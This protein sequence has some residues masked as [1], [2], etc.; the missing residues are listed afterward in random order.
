MGKNGEAEGGGQDPQQPQGGG[1]PQG[2]GQKGDG[3][4][5]GGTKP[6]LEL[7]DT[8]EALAATRKEAA[9]NRTENKKLRDELD[10][11]KKDLGKALGLKGESGESDDVKTLTATVNKLMSKLGTAERKEA[12]RTVA[13]AVGADSDLAW[14]YLAANGKL[15]DPDVD[16]E[17]ALKA[18]LKEKPALK[19]Q[20]AVKTGAEGSEGG[21]SKT[22]NMNTF[23]RRA[24]GR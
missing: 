20:G 9:Q 23:I 10:S 1:T 2:G 4:G 11:L 24:A 5:D 19:A 12:F 8:R 18:A 16:V 15:D 7:K 6:Q 14:A 21:G 13:K 22:K 17:K 3:G